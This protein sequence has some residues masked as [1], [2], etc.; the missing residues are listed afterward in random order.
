MYGSTVLVRLFRLCTHQH[1]AGDRRTAR[2]AA[3]SCASGAV[4]PAA[5]S[6]ATV[7]A[8]MS[9]PAQL[10]L[11]QQ[12]EQERVEAMMAET[13]RSLREAQNSIN[14]GLAR[15][16]LAAKAVSK[17]NENLERDRDYA[18]RAIDM[19]IMSTSSQVPAGASVQC[20]LA[21]TMLLKA[22]NLAALVTFVRFHRHL[23]FARFELFMDDIHDGI[24]APQRNDGAAAV[25]AELN[26][27]SDADI[28]VHRCNRKWWLSREPE[29]ETQSELGEP[30][31]AAARGTE[32]VWE[33]WGKH[34]WTE[35]IAR[36]VVAV[37][38]AIRGSLAVGCHWLLHIDV[39]E[40]LC[41]GGLQASAAGHE[42]NQPGE[43]V[44]FFQRLPAALDQVTFLNHEAAPE[45][46]EIGDWFKECTLFK[47]SPSAGGDSRNFVAYTNGKS[48]VR[49]APGVIPA[50]PHRFTSVAPARRLH[51]IVVS[52]QVISAQSGLQA[53]TPTDSTPQ[54]EDSEQF[55]YPVL[56]H[57][58]NCGFEEW[59]RKYKSLGLFK[60]TFCGKAEI[61]FKFHLRSRDLLQSNRSQ[62]GETED[63]CDSWVP[64]PPK[65]GH[66]SP[67]RSLSMQT[68]DSS[69]GRA[70]TKSCIAKDGRL[71]AAIDMYT[72]A[73]V[74]DGGSALVCAGLASGRFVRTNAV[75]SVVGLYSGAA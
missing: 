25:L 1:R 68:S 41:C 65:Y 14:K 11:R 44:Q 53:S 20:K 33:Q 59:R 32:S 22:P 12:M 73:M 28:V 7:A 40:A 4:T 38:V 34:I 27:H 52:D 67:R 54:P 70:P 75:A 45:T 18:S 42:P 51:S 64:P 60:N 24:D 63:T 39:D 66:P 35:V 47:R 49:L 62:G 16:R 30:R 48:A 17:A 55:C 15:T 57:Y 46:C 13:L 10:R 58:P 23:G 2:R 71:A 31:E 37:D 21:I 26:A 9:S 36:Q 72:Q 3:R 56:L 29:P 69:F 74:H 6:A 8:R 50:G 5:W 43:A 19:A 61:P